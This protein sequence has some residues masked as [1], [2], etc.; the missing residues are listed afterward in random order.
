MYKLPRRSK[1][2]G[3]VVVWLFH[4]NKIWMRSLLSAVASD[5]CFQFYSS[6]DCTGDLSGPPIKI[7]TA[8]VILLHRTS[9][10]MS[11]TNQNCTTYHYG[12]IRQSHVRYQL[13]NV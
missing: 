4:R 5:L 8:G 13:R 2:K 6:D 11:G 9:C 3:V 10:M 1:W 7:P 12:N